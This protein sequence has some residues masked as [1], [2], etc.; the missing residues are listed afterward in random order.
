MKINEELGFYKMKLVDKCPYIWKIWVYNSAGEL[1][2]EETFY[3][4]AAANGYSRCLRHMGYEDRSDEV[5]Y[6]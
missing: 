1:D 6:K 2:I 5:E 3:G 4:R